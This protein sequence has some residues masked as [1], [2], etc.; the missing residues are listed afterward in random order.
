MTTVTDN[1][2]VI[3]TLNVRVSKLEL[4]LISTNIELSMAIDEVNTMRD[5][6]HL[7]PMTPTDHWDKETCHNNQLLLNIGK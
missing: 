2:A 3:A 1:S 6:H 4:A 5:I 7:D